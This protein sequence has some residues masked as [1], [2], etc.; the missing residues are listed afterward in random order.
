MQQH[1]GFSYIPTRKGVAM[2]FADRV[3]AGP[4]GSGPK[5]CKVARVIAELPDAERGA[6]EAMLKDMRWSQRALV[7]EFHAEGIDLSQG[8]ISEHRA[9]T[10]I[11]RDP[12]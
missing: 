3:K 9:G 8:I 12:R 1:A 4:S 7:I 10:C 2:S 6:A 11:C 5:R